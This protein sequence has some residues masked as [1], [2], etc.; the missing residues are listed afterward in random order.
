M[1]VVLKLNESGSFR[2]GSLQSI[3]GVGRFGQ[4]IGVGRFGPEYFGLSVGPSKADGRL[5]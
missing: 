2:S 5:V 1:H 3:L 4:S